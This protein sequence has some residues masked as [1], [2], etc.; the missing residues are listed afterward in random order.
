MLH[1]TLTSATDLRQFI[2]ESCAKLLVFGCSS[3]T[4]QN[5]ALSW[6]TAGVLSGISMA[7]DPDTL[8]AFPRAA[9]ALSRQLA[10]LNFSRRNREPIPVFELR[11]A[12]AVS[13]VIVAANDRPMFVR[14]DRGTWQ[15]FLLAGPALP[16]LDEPLSRDHVL[17]EHY[18]RL[19]PVLIFLRHCFGR[20]VG[21][22][23]EPTARLIID[24][25]LLTEQYGFWTT[26][27]AKS[28]Q[29]SNYGTSIAFIPWNFWRTSRRGT[30]R[31]SQREF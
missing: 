15:V 5:I 28:M 31:S 10:G 23:P 9:I 20:V 8:F 2:D 7:D 19:I 26:V 27:F 21:M 11:D 14:I 6:L 22:A 18:D 16:D 13:E 30:A 17:Q 4:E 3:S 29:H 25:P 1:K 24:D 12:T